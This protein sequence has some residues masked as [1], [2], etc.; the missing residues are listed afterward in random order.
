M[1]AE[2]PGAEKPKMSTVCMWKVPAM[3]GTPVSLG[4]NEE[5][6]QQQLTV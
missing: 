3:A 6:V 5:T 2:T 4:P 1:L